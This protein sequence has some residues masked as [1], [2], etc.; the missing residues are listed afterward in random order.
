MTSLGPMP[1]PIEPTTIGTED[2]YLE[3][4]LVPWD[5]EIFGFP[6]AQI[7][8][9]VL[10]D[11]VQAAEIMLQFR[12]WCVDR[13]VRLVSCRIDHAKL[14]ESMV[15]EGHGFR[16]IEFVYGPRLG[17]F[18]YVGAPLHSIDVL[19]ATQ[20]DLGQIEEIASTAFTTGRFLLDRRLDPGLSRR[21]Y[22][23][24]VRNS[25]RSQSQVVLKAEIDRSLVGF[26]VVEH[27][28]DRSVYW[29]L[30]AIASK[31]QGKGVGLSLWQT[32]LLRHKSEQASS[33]T[34]TISGH[35][36]RAL[37]L[38]ARLGFRITSIEMTF[39]WLREA[40]H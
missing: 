13:D 32:M 10:P 1:Q 11:S 21:R 29:H 22:A 20:D 38:Y 37:N 2:A 16:F 27:L 24:W 26:F 19:V 28:H 33:V 15:L 4:A 39:H 6:V 25:L 3:C 14:R 23:A 36:V 17:S 12:R 8:G 30:T 18:D 5:S 31:W 34:T 7:S 35:N 9:L 40:E